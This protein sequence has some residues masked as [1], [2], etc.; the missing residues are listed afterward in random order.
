MDWITHD[1][2]VW[3]EFEGD[4]PDDLVPGR[5]YRGQVDGFAEFGV[6]VNIGGT[7][8][9][10][11]RSELDRRIEGL[12]WDSGDDVFVQVEAIR[13]NGD[14]D[15]AWSIR[16]S[17]TEFRGHRVQDPEADEP[18]PVDE[19]PDE[20][21]SDG[22]LAAEHEV[23]SAEPDLPPA[24]PTAA[25]ALDDSLEERVRVEGQVETVRQTGG[26][27]LFEVRDPS[28]VATCAAFDGAGVRAYPDIDEGDFVGVEGRVEVYRDRVQ[29]ETDELAV[30][31]EDAADEVA[32]ALS[33][34]ESAAAQPP[35]A[36][37]IVEST[38]E[39]LAEP[40]AAA[41]TT[42]R[43]AVGD[44]RRVVI[45]H[46]DGVDATVAGVAL[47]HAVES[48]IEERHP[49][50]AVHQLLHRSPV[51][52]AYDTGDATHDLEARDGRP[53]VVLAGVHDVAEGWDLLTAYD[54]PPVVVSGVPVAVDADDEPAA[55]EADGPTAIADGEGGTSA[56]PGAVVAPS[57]LS[58]RVSDTG[59]ASEVA[60]RVEPAVRDRIAHYPA[61]GGRSPSDA[62]L[63]AAD[64]AGVDREAVRTRREAVAMAAFHHRRSAKRQLLRDV[65]A[66]EGVAD[67]LAERYRER[68][69]DA[70]DVALANAESASTDAG[71]V[72][73]LDAEAYTDR[74]SFPSAD[75]LAGVL[76]DERPDAIATIVAGENDLQWRSD[77]PAD[78]RE[79]AAAIA[80]GAE[81]GLHARP[82]GG[83]DGRI[84]YPPAE[85]DAVID[86]LVAELGQLA[87]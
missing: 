24:T 62:A 56:A 18:Q 82:V 74:Y 19:R 13:D 27:T 45:R 77:V 50:A 72:T 5:F 40:I 10:L 39:A 34:A 11:H 17:P 58:D 36:D 7:T 80:S 61:V 69:D 41:A 81:G 65:L 78:A 66:G 29:V 38:A 6:F 59:A 76:H 64:E 1:E 75:H 28:G 67:R 87:A 16:Q 31:D 12:D 63:S 2:D 83:P 42:I 86:A 14:V 79:L 20:P 9:L 37:P 3:F 55:A 33:D 21:S 47:E 32:E 68:I 25:A 49:D 8:G 44:E 53:L 43:R 35:T 71:P 15:L 30:L 70:L 84:A 51:R 73:V 23:E 54:A 26:P 46:G 52:D 48:L 57:S 4:D 60:I 85:R 22:G